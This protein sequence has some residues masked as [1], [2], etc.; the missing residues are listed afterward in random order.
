[1]AVAGQFGQGLV[2]RLHRL[3]RNL[4]VAIYRRRP[5]FRSNNMTQLDS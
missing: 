1:L 3:H 2:T 5:E 4:T